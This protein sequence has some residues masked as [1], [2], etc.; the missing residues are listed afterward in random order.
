[1]NKFDIYLIIKIAFIC[2][3]ILVIIILIT[4]LFV[5]SENQKHKNF[6]AFKI[7]DFFLTTFLVLIYFTIFVFLI[8][9]LRI[10]KMGYIIDLKPQ[11]IFQKLLHEQGYYLELILLILNAFKIIKNIL[12]IELLKIHLYFSFPKKKNIFNDLL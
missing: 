8:L 9:Y 1:M 7:K 11:I 5:K 12:T 10:S 6:Y 2:L 3:L 4:T